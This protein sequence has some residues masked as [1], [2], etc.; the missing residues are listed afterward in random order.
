MSKAK[1][2][3]ETR[4]AKGE[5]TEQEFVSIIERLARNSVQG[6][7][8]IPT[9]DSDELNNG[10]DELLEN[11]MASQKRRHRSESPDDQSPVEATPEILT[12][13]RNAGL[14]ADLSLLAKFIK[15][16]ANITIYTF[17]GL[18]I[19]LLKRQESLLDMNGILKIV[20]M[21]TEDPS[22]ILFC[23][24]PLL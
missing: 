20:A 6:G 11:S 9:H 8:D 22:E 5:I 1:E 23:L 10:V 12:H 13:Y 24:I 21:E 3:A 2:I 17:I 19:L 7:I 15:Y 18:F 4:F 16:S 14:K